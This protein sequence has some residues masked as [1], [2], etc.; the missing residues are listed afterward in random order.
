MSYREDCYTQNGHV[1]RKELEHTVLVRRMPGAEKPGKRR[2]VRRKLHGKDDAPYSRHGHVI[3]KARLLQYVNRDI[4]SLFL[5]L[6]YD[7]LF[8]VTVTQLWC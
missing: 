1:M 3:P 5:R 6:L 8:T 4:T 7:D 2:R